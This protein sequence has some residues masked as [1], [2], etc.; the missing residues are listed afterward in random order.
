MILNTNIAN[1]RRIYIF[2]GQYLL[3]PGIYAP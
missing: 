2:L 1:L 3:N